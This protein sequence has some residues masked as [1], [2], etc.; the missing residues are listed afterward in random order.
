MINDKKQYYDDKFRE[1]KDNIKYTWH[2]IKTI[3]CKNRTSTIS[4]RFYSGNNNVVIS[5]KKQI[6]DNFNSFF[7]NIGPTL[8]NFFLTKIFDMKFFWKF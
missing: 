6:S 7:K 1:N 8:A 5:D 4:S 2:M 3:I